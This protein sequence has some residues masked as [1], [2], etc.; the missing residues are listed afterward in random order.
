MER[1]IAFIT[2]PRRGLLLLLIS[3]LCLAAAVTLSAAWGTDRYAL[4]A[5]QEFNSRGLRVLPLEGDVPSAAT[6]DQ[7]ARSVIVRF[8]EHV[9]DPRTKC[10]VIYENEFTGVKV[11]SS[12]TRLS[13]MPA[14]ID[15]KDELKEGGLVDVDQRLFRGGITVSGVR[16]DGT[17]TL[18]IEGE[19]FDLGPGGVWSAARVK[20][21]TK[22][23]SLG[24]TSDLEARLRR[25]LREGAP[26]SRLTVVNYGLWD[27]DRVRCAMGGDEPS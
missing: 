10:L 12:V 16:R 1:A 22:I 2:N 3:S 21:G 26:V 27:A 5:I 23:V 19:R 4:I 11:L 15:P 17:V 9:P 7:A 13:K 24:P 25:A 20:E 8:P 6:V 18:E 14:S